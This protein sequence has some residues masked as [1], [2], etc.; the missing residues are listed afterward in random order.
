MRISNVENAIIR[1]NF[2]GQ[3]VRMSDVAIIK[4]GFEEPRVASKVM[5][6]PGITFSILKSETSDIITLSN[7]IAELIS[8]YENS[9]SKITSCANCQNKKNKPL[10]ELVL[11]F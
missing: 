8:K 6:K 4:D 7:K 2:N 1:S 5:G 11:L 10:R 3:S 9:F